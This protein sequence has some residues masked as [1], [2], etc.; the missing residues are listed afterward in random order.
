LTDWDDIS[1]SS[2]AILATSCCVFTRGNIDNDSLDIFDVSDV[3]YFIDFMLNDGEVPKCA[4]ESDVND[5]ANVDIADL[6]YIVNFMF[7]D[8][9]PPYGCR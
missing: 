3:V 8:G 9:P 7:N 6:V 2:N 4:H 1:F 5:D